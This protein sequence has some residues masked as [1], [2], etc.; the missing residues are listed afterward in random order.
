[1]GRRACAERKESADPRSGVSDHVLGGLPP[2]TPSALTPVP[3]ERPGNAQNASACRGKRLDRSL[4]TLK[5][6]T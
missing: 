1:M 6:R 5:T 4:K 2:P 3:A